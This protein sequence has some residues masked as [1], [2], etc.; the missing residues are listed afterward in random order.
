[1]SGVKGQ[2]HTLDIV[3]N[4]LFNLVNKIQTESFGLG[5]SNLVHSL[6]M[7]SGRHLLSFKVRVKGQGH[8]K[9]C[10]LTL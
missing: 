8:A 1:M 2:G 7:T 5:R 4:V 3:K 6:L 9:H 10:S